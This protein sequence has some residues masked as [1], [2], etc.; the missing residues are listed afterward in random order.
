MNQTQTVGYGRAQLAGTGRGRLAKLLGSLLCLQVIALAVIYYNRYPLEFPP[1]GMFGVNGYWAVI[2]SGVVT[3]T[4]LA[5]VSRTTLASFVATV[6]F[7]VFMHSNKLLYYSVPGGDTTGELID[8]SMMSQ[9]AS[10]GPG[11]A[12]EFGYLRWP[13]N[14]TFAVLIKRV[15]EIGSLVPVVDLGYAIYTLAFVTAVWLF[16]SRL[17]DGF[18]AFLAAAAYV[19]LS[20]PVLNNQFVPQFM[21][22]VLLVFLFHTIDRTGIQWRVV[23]G[24]LFVALV[25]A[26]PVFPVFYPLALMFRPAIRSLA[27]D[28]RENTGHQTVAAGLRHPF[29]SL[30]RTYYQASLIPRDIPFYGRIVGLWGIYLMKNPPG[31]ILSNFT[32]VGGEG[33]GSPVLRIVGAVLPIS[34]G[35]GASNGGGTEVS[36]L[37]Q[38]VPE[39][40]DTVVS[41]GSRVVIIA[42]FGLLVVAFLYTDIG[43][44]LGD[45]GSAGSS[46]YRLEII[47]ASTLLLVYAAVISATYGIR[48]LQVAF[49]PIA[50]FT[51]GMHT[52]KRPAVVLVVF[53]LVLSPM[54]LVNGYTDPTLRAGGNTIGYHETQ[55][56]YAI[57]PYSDGSA[58]LVPARTPT[59]IGTLENQGHTDLRSVVSAERAV[60]TSGLIVYSDRLTS[61]LEL[62]GHDCRSTGVTDDRIYDG[63]ADVLD[64]T[65]NDQP[66]NCLRQTLG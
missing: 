57:G 52:L 6:A 38:Y 16:A 32:E 20:Y 61:Y 56:G 53:L 17:G 62:H 3:T 35:N 55:A 14:Y 43:S 4:A 58:V 12:A 10:V 19:V 2:L 36:L 8:L 60:P 9:F 13:L 25:F 1:T 63:G 48:V 54:L 49:L 33:A 37:Y 64:T 34:V 5:Y 39:T 7:Y 59:P 21:A 27:D 65:S 18:S 15:F 44:Q 46:D 42:L 22:L 51:V 24:V 30:K 29:Q 45:D 47:V 66:S 11:L 31:Y 40:L 23:E 28:F 41:W 50:M 26:H